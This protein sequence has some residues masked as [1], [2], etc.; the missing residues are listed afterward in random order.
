M[1]P[2]RE[3]VHYFLSIIAKPDRNAIV[4]DFPGLPI[5]VVQLVFIEA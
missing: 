3:P 5:E 2:S 1:A 4:S